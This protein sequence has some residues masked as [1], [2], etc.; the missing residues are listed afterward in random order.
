MAHQFS[1]S[2]VNDSIALLRYYKTLADRAMAQVGDEDLQRVIDPESNSVA[3]LVKHMAGNMR[4]RW[5]DFL[6]SDGEKP[7]R[8]RDSE[9]ETAPQSRA[10]IMDM[11]EAGWQCV[12]RALEQLTAADLARRVNIRGEPHSVMQAINRQVAHYS[13]HVGQIILLCK[14][15]KSAGWQSLTVP[16]RGSAE[17]NRKVAK[18]KASQR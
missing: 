8:H 3:I 9:F 2:Y 14:H 10:E 1:T 11:W 4:S 13:Y 12:F 15:F 18:V 17:F 16:R 6:T 5:T 7:D